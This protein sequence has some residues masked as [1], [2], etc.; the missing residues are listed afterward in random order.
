MQKNNIVETSPAFIKTDGIK[1][2]THVSIPAN[3][4]EMPF[5]GVVVKCYEL[6][7]EPQKDYAVIVQ[8]DRKLM[9]IEAVKSVY[10]QGMMLCLSNEL[11]VI[12]QP[13]GQTSIENR[14]H[15]MEDCLSWDGRSPE[16]WYVPPDRCSIYSNLSTVK[17]K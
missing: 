9:E 13:D 4:P 10:P 17:K 1:S 16:I 12:A 11:H 15:F 2:G 14:K 6:G 5:T 7:P 8:L 3:D